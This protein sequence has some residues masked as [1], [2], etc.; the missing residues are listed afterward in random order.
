M[1]RPVAGSL[2]LPERDSRF[3]HANAV[4]IIRSEGFEEPKKGTVDPAARLNLCVDRRPGQPEFAQ[5]L[6]DPVRI[7]C[8]C[9][10]LPGHGKQ[11]AARRAETG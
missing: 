9:S 3:D 6:L 7:V 8:R 1:E 5:I 10:P 11:G 4:E 2:E